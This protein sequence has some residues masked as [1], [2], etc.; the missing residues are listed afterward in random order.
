MQ[1]LAALDVC[2]IPY[3]VIEGRICKERSFG[4]T[5]NWS[6]DKKKKKKK[7]RRD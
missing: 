3:D 7:E 5:K 2:L 6:S 1:L 4:M